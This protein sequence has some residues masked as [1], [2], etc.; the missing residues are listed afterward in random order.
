[1]SSGLT[2]APVLGVIAA[3]GSAGP[4]PFQPLRRM[5]A[6]QPPFGFRVQGPRFMIVNLALRAQRLIFRVYG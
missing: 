5:N 4:E 1:L 3:S 6:K 2:V